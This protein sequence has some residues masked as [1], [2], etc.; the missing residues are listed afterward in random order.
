MHTIGWTLHLAGIRRFTEHLVPDKDRSIVILSTVYTLVLAIVVMLLYFSRIKWRV[1]LPIILLLY[2]AVKLTEQCG[3]VHFKEGWYLPASSIFIWGMY[4]Y[5]YLLDQ[6]YNHLN[7]PG[8]NLI[9][10][11]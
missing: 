3:L 10:D 7:K 5:T 1:K 8:T 4:F 6:M 11:L 9:R 2:V